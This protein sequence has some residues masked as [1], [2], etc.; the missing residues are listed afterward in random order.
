MA[1]AQNKYDEIDAAFLMWKRGIDIPDKVPDGWFTVR[2]FASK[3]KICERKAQDAIRD[4]LDIG[5]LQSHK[6]RIQ[7]GTRI[8]PVQHY[9]TC[10]PTKKTP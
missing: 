1:S 3:K 2:E 9:K 7:A 4:L 6:F 10:K 5:V 8:Y